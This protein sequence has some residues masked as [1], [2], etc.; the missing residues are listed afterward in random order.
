MNEE[1]FVDKYLGQLV[2]IRNVKNSDSIGNVIGYCGKKS[3]NSYSGQVLIR[4]VEGYHLSHLRREFG[5]SSKG[6]VFKV[7]I[8]ATECV[9]WLVA[10]PE[11]IELLE[12]PPI[13]NAPDNCDDCG[14]VGEEECKE[15]C[16]NK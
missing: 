9:N 11:N 13:S 10:L 15:E 5:Y 1:E 16:P 8:P 2:R 4:V 12:S 6:W 14:A 3:D 7:E